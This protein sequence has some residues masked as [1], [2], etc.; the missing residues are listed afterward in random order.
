L[1]PRP[2]TEEMKE[3]V[4]GSRDV[5]LRALKGAQGREEGKARCGRLSIGVLKLPIAERGRSVAQPSHESMIRM[6]SELPDTGPGAWCV[7]QV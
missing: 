4:S 2:P 5:R 1:L 3:H 7:L 6:E